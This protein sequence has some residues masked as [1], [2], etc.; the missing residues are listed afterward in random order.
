MYSALLALVF[1]ATPKPVG[2]V[3]P[4]IV[5]GARHHGHEFTPWE[6]LVGLSQPVCLYPGYNKL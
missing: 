2:G 1:L 3:D 5:G 4:L 6:R